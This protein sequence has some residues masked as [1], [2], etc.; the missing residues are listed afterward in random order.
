MTGPNPLH[1]KRSVIIT[2]GDLRG[3]LSDKKDGASIP[4]ISIARPNLATWPPPKHVAKADRA[5]RTG[6]HW[7]QFPLPVP[8]AGQR[9]ISLNGTVR[10]ISMCNRKGVLFT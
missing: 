9:V 5:D 2:A 8:G 4:S 6:G 10:T 7:T 1:T 3:K